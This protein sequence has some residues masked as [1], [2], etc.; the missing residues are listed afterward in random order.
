MT[1]HKNNVEPLTL[2]SLTQAFAV[3]S[4][5][6]KLYAFGEIDSTNTHGAEHPRPDHRRK[7]NGRSRQAWAQLL[8]PRR[9]RR[10][11]QHPVS[12]KRP[13]AKRGVAHGGGFGCRNARDP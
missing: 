3:H 10:V 4:D 11:F 5:A 13:V 9:K 7:P 8:L 6:P 2:K 12:H 1:P